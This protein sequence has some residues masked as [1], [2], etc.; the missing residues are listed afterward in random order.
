[1]FLNFIFYHCCSSLFLD[2]FLEMKMYLLHLSL[3]F[4]MSVHHILAPITGCR[5]NSTKT[6]RCRIINSA[7]NR[8]IGDTKKSESDFVTS[9]CWELV[10][11]ISYRE[12]R[13][14]PN[15]SEIIIMYQTH[16]LKI[17]S[18]NKSSPSGRYGKYCAPHASTKQ[19]HLA[20][21]HNCKSCI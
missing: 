11:I 5:K 6:K 15:K 4:R 13:L 14:Y 21:Y 2:W 17:Y 18:R 12:T 10:W 20:F 9:I 16:G 7:E 19:Q 3:T 1:M 8:D